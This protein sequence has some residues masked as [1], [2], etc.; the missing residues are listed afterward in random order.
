MSLRDEDLDELVAD[1]CLQGYE[2]TRD[3]GR[4][5]GETLVLTFPGGKILE[6]VAWAAD[7]HP[8]PSA[9]LNISL[10]RPRRG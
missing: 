3:A 5:A 10:L 6:L 4:W 1:G 8:T 9:G 7:G 2:Y